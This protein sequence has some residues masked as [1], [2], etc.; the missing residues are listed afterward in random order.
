MIMMPAIIAVTA[1][2]VRIADKDMAGHTG[3]AVRPVSGRRGPPITSFSTTPRTNF[4]IGGD[5]YEIETAGRHWSLSSPD[6]R[7][8]RFEI[9]PGDHAW[10]DTGSVDRSQV[11]R[12]SRIPEGTAINISY[13]F[14]LEP[15]AAITAPWFVTGELHNEDSEAGV[16][17]SPPVAIELAG[18]HLRVVAR[19]CPTGLNPSN[20]ARNLKMLRLWTDPDAIQRGRYY[21]IKIQAGID[22]TSNGSL[23][24]WVGGTQVVNYHGPLGYGY[25]TYWLEGLY[26]SAHQ[27]QTV[28][29]D[30]RDLSVTTG[31]TTTGSAR[32]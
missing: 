13:E 7:T 5:S 32:R 2:V 21:D 4:L 23:D 12:R 25:P 11:E 16:P 9:R 29:A 17:T 28:A 22:N 26:R 30:F 3:A 8:L 14:M 20:R 6:D 31:S 18:E 27:S 1:N 15:G 10:F 19:Y 24:V